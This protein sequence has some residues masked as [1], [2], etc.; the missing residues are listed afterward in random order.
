MNSLRNFCKTNRSLIRQTSFPVIIT[1]ALLFTSC[2]GNRVPY[3]ILEFTGKGEV[4]NYS[5]SLLPIQYKADSVDATALLAG[6][7]DII[8]YGDN[9]CLIYRGSAE[10]KFTFRTLKNEGFINEKINSITIPGNDDMIPW[11]QHMKSTDIS[12]LDFIYFDASPSE[13]YIP[14]LTD[15]AKSKPD[16]G[17]GYD[18]DLAD[19]GRILEIFKPAFILGVS[20]SQQDIN[21]LSGLDNLEFLSAS[22]KDSVYPEPLPAM[23]KLKQLILADTPKNV[24]ISDDFLINNK[25]IEKLIINESGKINLSIIKTLENLR[26]LIINGPG[27]IENT[28]LIKSNKQLELLSVTGS[29]L[30]NGNDLKE[31]TGIRW[32]TFYEDISQEGFNS[33]TEAHPNLEVVELINNDSIGDLRQLL[34]LKSLYGLVVT[35]TLTDFATVKSLKSLKYLSIPSDILKDA[36]KKA[37]L[38]NELPA[39]IIVANYGVCLGSGWLLLIFPFI[40]L[41]RL[42]SRQKA[43]EVKNKL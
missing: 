28:G 19:M 32:I 27:K 26:E 2:T 8:V 37:E 30:N 5:K 39:T 3:S 17:L 35:D 21:H 24:I 42:F 13:S 4:Y 40:I 11:F 9:N 22:L 20:L 36:Q 10:R 25:Q 34:N 7:G 6:R 23:P 15:L 33:F 31:L 18:G 43:G 14:Y 38:Q 16:P 1:V 41:L 12:G 29:M